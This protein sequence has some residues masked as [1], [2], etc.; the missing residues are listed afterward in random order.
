M[1]WQSWALDASER[2]IKTV[3]QVL[4]ALWATSATLGD[5]NWSQT[6]GTAGLAGLI[7]LATSLASAPIGDKG[8]ASVVASYGKHSA[9]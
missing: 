3:A 7:S 8:S 4:V 1:T 6:L 9:Q 5:V 2:A